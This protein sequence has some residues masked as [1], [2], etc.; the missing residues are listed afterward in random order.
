TMTDVTDPTGQASTMAPPVR[1]NDQC[2]PRIKWVQTGYLKFNAKGTKREVFGMPVPGSLI[3]ADLQEASYYQEYLENVVKHRWLCSLWHRMYDTVMQDLGIPKQDRINLRRTFV[4][5]FPAQSNSSSN[6]IALDLPN[7]LVLNTGASQSRQ[8]GIP[9]VAAA[10]QKGRQFTTLCPLF[11]LI[12]DVSKKTFNTTSA[13]L[14]SKDETPEVLIDFLRLVQRGLHAQ[15]RTVQ[16]NRGTE[17]LNKT[18]HAYFAAE[19]INHQ[20]SVAQ[21]PKQNSIV[22]RQNRTLV[23]AARTMLSAVKF[24]YYFGLK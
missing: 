10:G 18:L 15:V 23:E 13:T 11:K 8:H 22:K 19:G 14:M 21:T 24:L 5:G 2:L 20:T 16:T 9:T 17:F 3:T 6:T 7:L 12:I 1:S 4:T